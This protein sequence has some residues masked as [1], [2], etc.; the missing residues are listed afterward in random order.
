MKNLVEFMQVFRETR[1]KKR[2]VVVDV[3]NTPTYLQGEVFIGVGST[4]RR[5]FNALSETG[6][7]VRTYGGR[8]D[9]VGAALDEEYAARRISKELEEDWEVELAG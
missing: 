8:A 4:L 7:S 2:W 6:F 9:A 3:R 1:G 5:A